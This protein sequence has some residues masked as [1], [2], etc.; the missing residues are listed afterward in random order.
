MEGDLMGESMFGKKERLYADARTKETPQPAPKITLSAAPPAA[1]PAAP[2][3]PPRPTFLDNP[4]AQVAQSRVRSAV[5]TVLEISGV[6]AVSV[7]GFLVAP[8]L[9]CMILGLLLIVLGVATGY[10]A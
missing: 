4:P 6:T 3:P 8:W 2:Q 5:S 1:A 9:G 10:G 7:G